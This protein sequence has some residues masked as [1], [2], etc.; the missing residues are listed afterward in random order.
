MKARRTI[1]I[2]D[3]HGYPGLIQ[4]ALDHAKFEPGKDRLIYAGDILDRGPDPGGCI[5]LIEKYATEVL[6]GNHD[7]AALFGLDIWPQNAES[8]AFAD[9]LREKALAADPEQA[10]KTA[11]CVEGILITHAGIGPQYDWVL[12]GFDADPSQ[13]A[14]HLNAQ[15]RNVLESG[16]PVKGWEFHALLGDDGPFWF[17]PWP[18]AGRRPLAS[19]RQIAGHTPPD[20]EL[21]ELE[22]SGFYLIDPYSYAF[23]DDPGRY[24]YAVIDNGEVRVEEGSLGQTG[25]CTDRQAA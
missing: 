15:L 19:M 2:S 24:R 16:A 6:L 10:W 1:V 23:E 4:N 5:A 17:R 7:I 25:T 18:R 12:Q 9:Y 14:G 11:T 13:L 20:P 21:K 8:P 3:A 22:D